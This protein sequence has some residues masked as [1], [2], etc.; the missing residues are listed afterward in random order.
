M[1]KRS[2]FY[3]KRALSPHAIILRT[4]QPAGIHNRAKQHKHF[5]LT[6]LC[7]LTMPITE[8]ILKLESL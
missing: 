7:T 5:T 8:A 4:Q 6:C 3:L 2:R 1:H